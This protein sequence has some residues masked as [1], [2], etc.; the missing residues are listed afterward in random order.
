MLINYSLKQMKNFSGMLENPT[1]KIITT[2]TFKALK[3][4]TK[5]F[6]EIIPPVVIQ[7]YFMSL[8]LCVL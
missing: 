1:K 6:N 7:K 5:L 4:K 8:N 2:V 3:T